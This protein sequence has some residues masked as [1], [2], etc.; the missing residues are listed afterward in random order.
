M[1][2]AKDKFDF[3][4]TQNPKSLIKVV[5]ELEKEGN[6]EAIDFKVIKQAKEFSDYLPKKFSD[7]IV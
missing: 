1:E 5:E 3:L 6:L 2:W 4:F 7:C